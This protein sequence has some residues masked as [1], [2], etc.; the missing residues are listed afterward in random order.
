MITYNFE[1]SDVQYKTRLRNNFKSYLYIGIIVV[2][3]AFYYFHFILVIITLVILYL[4]FKF[5][6]Q[7]ENHEYICKIS[8]DSNTVSIEYTN[9]EKTL[10]LQGNTPDFEFKKEGIDHKFRSVS[11]VVYHHNIEQI[12]QYSNGE[13]TIDKMVDVIQTFNTINA[14]GEEPCD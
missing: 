2:P 14:R 11:F 9:F 1:N 8:F 3:L 10:F 13:W 5:D 12:R 4:Y 6:S 7:W